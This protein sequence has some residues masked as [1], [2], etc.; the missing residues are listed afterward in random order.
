MKIKVYLLLIALSFATYSFSLNNSFV[1]DDEEHVQHNPAIHQIENVPSFF[2][3]STINQGT[4]DKM[5]GIY[6]KP[7]LMTTY[8]TVWSLFGGDP[9]YFHILQ[10]FLHGTN[11]FL[12]FLILVGFT[13]T[14]PALVLALVFLLHPLNTENAV[15]ISNYQDILFTLFGLFALLVLKVPKP[16]WFHHLGLALLLLCSLLCKESGVLFLTAAT[17]F[18]FIF[19]PPQRLK[20]IMAIA[21]AVLVY[22]FL[23]FGLAGL[24]NVFHGVAP[25]S[26]ISALERFFTSP[27]AL[28]HYF[29]L[30]VAPVHFTTAQ[31]WVVT[32]PTFTSFWLPFLFVI[33]AFALVVGLNIRRPSKPLL[34]FSLCLGAGLFLHSQL[35]AP[36]D[37]TVA[38]RWFY[39]PMFALLGIFAVALPWARLKRQHV[40]IV[41]IPLLAVL[42][43]RSFVRS[44]DWESGY[45]LYKHDLSLAPDA[46]DIQNNFGVELFRRSE[47]DE[48]MKHFLKSTE[49]A[50]HWTINWNNLGAAYEKFGQLDKAEKAYCTSVNNGVYYLAFEN[51]AGLL[52]KKNLTSESLGFIEDVGLVGLPGNARLLS[53]RD[54]LRTLNVNAKRVTLPLSCPQ[55]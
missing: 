28:F 10:I 40:L 32:D 7:L 33:A 17:L 8:A 12:I 4:P 38:D 18:V 25:I 48:A 53:F 29:K 39:F 23:R 54:Y 41:A 49:L 45:T 35:L 6:Y 21:S 3:T 1:F 22:A 9:F 20:S 36:L 5:S 43:T 50:P 46:Y 27:A 30:F 47:Y 16:K 14:L 15:Y 26:R 24:Y 51:Y 44:L 13:S 37:A 34:F 42:A 52:I 31:N 2:F 19:R 55:S 11:A